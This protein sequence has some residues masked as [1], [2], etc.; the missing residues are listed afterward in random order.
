MYDSI[1]ITRAK[2]IDQTIALVTENEN[3][4]VK[5]NEKVKC[6]TLDSVKLKVLAPGDRSR[7]KNFLKKFIET[8]RFGNDHFGAIM[9]YE[10]YVIGDSVISR[11]KHSCYVRDTDDV[12]LIKSSS[13]SNLY[14]I[15]FEVL[16]H[17]LV[18]QSLQE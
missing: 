16:S 14:T 15:S 1:Q 2:Y 3:L 5:I 7:L 10:D 12:E 13:G 6:V 11:G 9:G 8:V 18:V 17:L 4:K